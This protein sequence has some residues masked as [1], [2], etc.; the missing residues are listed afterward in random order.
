ALARNR[1]TDECI[2]GDPLLWLE[3]LRDQNPP[4]LVATGRVRGKGDEVRGQGGIPGL[5]ALRGRL[6]IFAEG[7]PEAIRPQMVERVA[8]VRPLAA[9]VGHNARIGAELEG[10]LGRQGQDLAW[11]L[12]LLGQ[13]QNEETAT[14]LVIVKGKWQNPRSFRRP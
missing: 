5:E 7:R 13:F 8:H 9:A 6:A 12:P 2:Q 10:E 4:R 11:Q 3:V 1:L 14:L